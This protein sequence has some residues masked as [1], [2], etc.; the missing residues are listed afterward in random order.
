MTGGSTMG[1][2]NSTG[3]IVI[4]LTRTNG[5]YIPSEMSKLLEDNIDDD[6]TNSY[7]AWPFHALFCLLFVICVFVSFF[8]CFCFS[9]R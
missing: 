8:F 5:P 4:Q 6:F 3:D 9:F 1:G 7:G 2:V